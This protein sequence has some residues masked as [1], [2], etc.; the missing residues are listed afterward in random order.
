MIWR[1]LKTLIS[2]AD[3]SDFTLDRSWYDLNRKRRGEWVKKMLSDVDKEAG[4]P[5]FSG[6]I[7]P[8]QLAMD[9]QKAMGDEDWL[10]I[11]GGNTHFW[12]EI[13]VNLAGYQGKKL[14]GILHPGTFSLLGVGC[15]LLSLQECSSDKNVV[16]ISGDGAF[17]SAAYRS[18]SVSKPAHNRGY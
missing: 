16:L 17:L 9:V 3:S 5:E 14:G 1:L 18:D 13:A 4:A 12:S 10:V 15:L 6:R 2:K 7:H 8:L 11:D